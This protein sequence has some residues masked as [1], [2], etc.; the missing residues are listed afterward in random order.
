MITTLAAEPEQGPDSDPPS[1]GPCT[2]THLVPGRKECTPGSDGHVTIDVD[3]TLITS[4]S[5][6]EGA[7]P[8]WKKIYGHHPLC[9]FIEGGP[10]APVSHWPRCCARAMP[11]P[12]LPTT[13]SRWL[14]SP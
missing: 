1:T 14:K 10:R 13:T 9:A 12:T 7:A 11:D 4:H 3:A 5:E 8:T 6:K 2:P